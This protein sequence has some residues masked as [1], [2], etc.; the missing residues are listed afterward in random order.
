M[1]LITEKIKLTPT[2]SKLTIKAPDVV[3]HAKPGQFVM[4]RVEENGERIPLTIA[5]S[6]INNGTISIIFQVVGSTT[7]KLDLLE[8]GDYL[9]DFAGPMGKP[10]K[11]E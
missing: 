4:L 1:F 7:Q 11:L 8:T 5:E 2:V 6:N 9:I 10:S 3:R